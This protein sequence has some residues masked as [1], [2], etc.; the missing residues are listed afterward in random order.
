MIKIELNWKKVS[1]E[2]C[3]ADVKI[4]KWE[5]VSIMENPKTITE[6][7]ITVREGMVQLTPAKGKESFINIDGYTREV[8]F[9][10]A[11]TYFAALRN[12]KHIFEWIED[13]DYDKRSVNFDD[14]GI[15]EED[16]DDNLNLDKIIYDKDALVFDD[17][18]DEED[19]DEWL[20]NIRKK[21]NK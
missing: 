1:D 5:E 10:M 7:V 13:R 4:N 6:L 18:M 20:D 3:S 11:R 21:E 12:E 15:V 9:A 16:E 14:E 17:L 8:L 19:D 2:E